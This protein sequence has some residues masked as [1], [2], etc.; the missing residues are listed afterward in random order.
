MVFRDLHDI[1]L[2]LEE[3]LVADEL[4]LENL[5]QRSKHLGC[6]SI[7]FYCLKL[8]QHFFNLNVEKELLD[9]CQPKSTSL[10]LRRYVLILFKK[11]LTPNIEKHKSK[12]YQYASFLLFMRSH[13]LKMPLHLLIPHLFHKSFITPFEQRKIRKAIEENR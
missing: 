13:W 11:V 8:Q 3:F 10:Y 9:R 6:E 5:F 4:F 7:L 1:Y 12:S 2:L